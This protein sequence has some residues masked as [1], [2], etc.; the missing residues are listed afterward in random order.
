L[1]RSSYRFCARCQAVACTLALT[2]L[3]GFSVATAEE[4]PTPADTLQIDSLADQGLDIAGTGGDTLLYVPPEKEPAAGEVTSRTDLERHLTQNPTAAL[5][6]SMLVPGLGQVG[7]HRY[8]KALLFAGL[9][10]WFVS[11][12]IHYGRQASDAATYYRA[13]TDVTLRYL[14]YNDY[15]RKRSN[16]NKFIW[17]AGITTFISMFDAYVDAH[18]SGSPTAERNEKY[19]FDVYPD[20]SGGVTASLSFNF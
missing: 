16:R 13:Q 18:L 19:S 2:I 11:R 20:E 9:E 4:T 5:F 15:S 6:K 10:G 3:F 7:N 12:A 1:A 14:A 17:F 8:F